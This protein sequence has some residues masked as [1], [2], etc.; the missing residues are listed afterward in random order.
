VKNLGC[1]RFQE[2][3]DG[4]ASPL[5]N[6]SRLALEEHLASCESCRADAAAIDQL[7][8][9][10]DELPTELSAGRR[11]RAIR[12]ALATDVR[13]VRP[14]RAPRP[15]ALAASLAAAAIVLAGI[16]VSW[17]VASDPA[18]TIKDDARK[19]APP[20][21]TEPSPENPSPENP[22]AIDPPSHLLAEAG[23]VQVFDAATVELP[24]GGEVSYDRDTRRLTLVRGFLRVEIDPSRH[25]SFRV[26]APR[27]SVLV[28]GT[29]FEIDE[30][31]VRVLRGVVQVLAPDGRVLVE[32]LEAGQ[33]WRA[34]L[35]PSETEAP[36]ETE[37]PDTSPDDARRLLARAREQIAA[38]DF[39]VA[40]RSIDEALAAPHG[41]REAAEA[42]T[43][44]AEMSKLRGDTAAALRAYR[45]VARRYARLPAGES[46]LFAAARIARQRG[47]R[48]E[49]RALFDEY[50][51]RYPHGRYRTEVMRN[52]EALDP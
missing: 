46:A 28:L 42:A 9:L 50:L 2:A 25:Q 3:L 44:R 48:A 41:T 21:E 23:A 37:A 15:W 43:L 20:S 35:E 51:S 19:A 4:R 52:R 8:A 26:D 29:I 1:L 16:G 6:A 40:G 22:S 13:A 32:R 39:G 12:A 27:F 47:D 7:R 17:I 33:S 36:T 45:D 18:M 31:Q 49:A 38:R 30:L 24:N 14:A 10:A 5:S 11:T 34:D